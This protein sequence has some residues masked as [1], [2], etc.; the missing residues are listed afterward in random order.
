MS[1]QALTQTEKPLTRGPGYLEV[2]IITLIVSTLTLLV[3]DRMFAQ[4]VRVVD[5]QGYLRTQKALLT[6][7]EI[8]QGQWQANLDT[9]DQVLNKEAATHQNHLFILNDVV[10]RNGNE[11]SISPQK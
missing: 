3:Y 9:V 8:T 1:E 6:A 11:T 10:L 7:G 2:I 4:K 5:L